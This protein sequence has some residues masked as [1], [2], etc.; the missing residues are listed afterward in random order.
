LDRLSKEQNTVLAFVFNLAVPFDK[1]LAERDLCM[2]KV[3]QKISGCFR[4]LAGVTAFCRIRGYLST[5]RIQG[6]ALLNAL[7]QVLLGH[8]IVPDFTFPE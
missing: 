3:Q 6:R 7:E 5:L 1:N 8:P 2:I 4:A